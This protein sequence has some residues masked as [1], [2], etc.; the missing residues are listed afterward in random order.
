MKPCMEHAL[1]TCMALQP[2]TKRIE[3]VGSLRRG[4]AEPHD[5][6]ILLLMQEGAEQ[7]FAGRLKDMGEVTWRRDYYGAPILGEKARVVIDDV[8]YDLL[9][10]SEDWWGASMLKFTGNRRFN[11]LCER[12]AKRQG[13]VL[14]ETG[15]YERTSGEY[16]HYYGQWGTH[17]VAKTEE[18]ILRTL[19]LSLYV[20]PATRELDNWA[21]DR[22][23]HWERTAK[24]HGVE[25]RSWVKRGWSGGKA[26]LSKW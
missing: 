13:L 10:V 3:V 22:L 1:L 19:G 20:D 6:D 23:S 17:R 25:A 12:I 15:L 9:R 11:E 26:W 24:Q 2:Y 7:D 4:V 8:K 18:E 14:D 21:I 16:D 5:I